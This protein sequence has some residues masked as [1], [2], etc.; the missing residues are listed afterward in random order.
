MHLLDPSAFYRQERCALCHVSATRKRVGLHPLPDHS[1]QLTIQ[2]FQ[3]SLISESAQKALRVFLA[4]YVPQM[5]SRAPP[6]RE[7]H[8]PGYGQHL[9]VAGIFDPSLAQVRDVGAGHHAARG[10][11]ELL[12]RPGG[13]VRAAVGTEEKLEPLGY[14]QEMFLKSPMSV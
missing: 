2:W 9:L 12:A 5:K 3:V 7:V 8:G 13:A 6:S 1:D 14:I 4:A 11:V 10:L